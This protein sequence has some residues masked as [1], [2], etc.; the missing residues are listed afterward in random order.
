MSIVDGPYRAN[1]AHTWALPG[2]RKC[3]ARGSAPGSGLRRIEKIVPT[4]MSASML[5]EPSSGSNSSR[6][7]PR[8]SVA[9]M[10]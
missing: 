6:Y 1:P 9:G 4:E 8:R 5:P 10:G 2:W 3:S 7:F